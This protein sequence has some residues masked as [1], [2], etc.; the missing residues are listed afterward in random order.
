MLKVLQRV[1]GASDALTNSF[2]AQQIDTLAAKIDETKAAALNALRRDVANRREP[3]PRVATT[4][5][6]SG[7][8]CGAS[9]AAAV[10]LLPCT[11][12]KEATHSSVECGAGMRL[13]AIKQAIKIFDCLNAS[14]TIT[15]SKSAI[16]HTGKLRLYYVVIT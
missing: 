2:L 5:A 14:C 4:L 8:C 11:T 15:L 3:W 9:G 13:A 16:G 1:T 10:L 6:Y 12:C 7:G